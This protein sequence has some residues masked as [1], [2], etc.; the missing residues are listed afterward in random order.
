MGGWYWIG[1]STGIGVA[2][3]V[4]AAVV[5]PRWL[6]AAIVAAALGAGLGFAVWGWPE[7]IGGGVG[8]AAG[9]IG[10]TPVVKGALRRGGT[11]AG[12]ALFALLGAV[13]IVAIAFVPVLGYLEAAALPAFGRRARSREPERYEGLRTLARD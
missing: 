3:G 6:L 11:R 13:A 7:A 2:L 10:A 1:V 5:L 8:G 12:L 4:L 9:A